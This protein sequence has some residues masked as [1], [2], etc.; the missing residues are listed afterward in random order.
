MYNNFA[1]RDFSRIFWMDTPGAAH[2]VAH[3]VKQGLHGGSIVMPELTEAFWPREFFDCIYTKIRLEN[4][5]VNL[6]AFEATEFSSADSF[7]LD[8]LERI[9]HNASLAYRPASWKNVAEYAAKTNAFQG[10]MVVVRHIAQAHADIWLRFA[11]EYARLCQS[12]MLLFCFDQGFPQG[13]F[14]RKNVL[15]L[16]PCDWI[17]ELD[18]LAL[19]LYSGAN[20][21]GASRIS[22]DYLARLAVALCG[23]YPEVCCRISQ[24][25]NLNTLEFDLDNLA[26]EYPSVFALRA[27]TQ[28]HDRKLWEAQVQTIFPALEMCRCGMLR[29]WGADI[30]ERLPLQDDYGTELRNVS[31][32]ELRHIVYFLNQRW[33]ILPRTEYMHVFEIYNARNQLAHLKSINGKTLKTLIAICE[34]Y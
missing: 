10:Q 5:D 34:N 30:I 31:D 14:N 13:E 1:A 29:K 8:L 33:L 28:E 26:E 17:T 23:G 4:S 7:E 21:T 2:M 11:V 3:A 6:T 15:T 16:R 12:G 24:L 18:L 27:G 9:N 20:T 22:L 19:A 32:I 25:G